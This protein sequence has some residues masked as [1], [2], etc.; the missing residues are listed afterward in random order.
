MS[1]IDINEAIQR[2]KAEDVVS[3]PTETVYGLA[4][5]I[6]SEKALNK[7]FKIK[8]RPFF[9]PLI[10][11]INNANQVKDLVS[12]YQKD[13]IAKLAQNFWPGPLTIVL[14]KNN[15]VP[16]L[17]TSGLPTVALR[18]PN[19]KYFLEA[20]TS[21]GPLAA[22]SAN[23]FGKTSPTSAN[24]VL[25]EFKNEVPVVDDGDCSVGIEST[26]LEINQE[27]FKI[28]RPG[29][30]T[31][32]QIAEVL[33][34]GEAEIGINTESANAPGHLKFHYQ[35]ETPLVLTDSPETAADDISKET[36]KAI[37][38][39]YELKL[40]EDPL[41]FARTMYSEFRRASK[42]DV[43][44]LVLNHHKKNT[45]IWGSIENRLTRAAT[46]DLR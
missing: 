29:I 25:E 8:E 9:D 18:I 46:W 5:S 23:K 27:G 38:K 32:Q 10:V 13:I 44:L 15:N 16:H 28:L 14:P 35:P 34:I 42:K 37:K 1:F 20:I 43:D 12:Y 40:P 41:L 22:P 21:V 11:H 39:T 7:I 30:I 31:K 45:G 26:I 33:E 6:K 2:L 24:H 3:L 17:V 4:G 36:G 19:N